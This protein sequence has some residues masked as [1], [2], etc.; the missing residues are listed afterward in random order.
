VGKYDRAG[1]ATDDN[2]ARAH[3]MLGKYRHTLG[4]S[5]TYCFPLTRVVTRTPLNVAFIRT[6]PFL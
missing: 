3:C 6:S 5:N 4:I 1:Q 2:M